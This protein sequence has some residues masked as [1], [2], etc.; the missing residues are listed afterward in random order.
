MVAPQWPR[1]AADR[2]GV[3][4]TDQAASGEVAVTARRLVDAHRDEVIERLLDYLRQPSVSATGEGFPEATDR[5]ARE[6]ELAGLRVDVLDT[7][8]RPAV[9]GRRDGPPGAPTVLVYGHYDVQPPGPRELWRTEPFDPVIA[10]GRIWGRGTGDN[11]GQHFAHLQA[12]RFLDEIVGGYPC[13]VKVILDGEEEVGSPHLPLVVERH[14]D[15]LAADLVLWSDGP[16]DESGR[17]CVLHG[18]RGIVGVRLVARGANRALHS[19]NYGN[20]A[21]NPAWSL[22]RALASLRDEDGQVAVA[23]FADD[24]EPLGPADRAAMAALPVD[25]QR[26]LDD[27]GVAAMDPAYDGVGYVERLA[28]IPTLT[29]NGIETGDTRRTIIPH[30]ATARIDARLVA[31]Q[32]PQRV[33]GVIADHLRRVAPDVDVTMEMAVPPSRTPIDNPYTAVVADAVRAVTGDAPL[34][35]PAL[36][37]TLPDYVWTKLLG[38][39]SLGL[40]IAN[41]D[42]SNHGPNENLEVDRYLTGI[43][44]SMSVLTAL[45]TRDGARTTTTTSLSEE[46]S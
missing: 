34:L 18:V 8:G 17:W 5:A 7:P 42:E 14:G 16:V 12:L 15:D 22:V 27:I 2:I 11:K 33:F 31:G 41:I 26:V 24:V 6:M 3:P 37:G 1:V 46:T 20:V 39:P 13:A 43:A 36:G 40:P 45:G 32:D 25:L 4:M 38:V 30:E 44:L 21:P 28:A 10:D 9:L 23:G 19:G 29:I 35:V